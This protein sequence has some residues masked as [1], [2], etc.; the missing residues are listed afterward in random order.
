MSKSDGQRR[1]PPEGLHEVSG[2]FGMDERAFCRA[3]WLARTDRGAR[4]SSLLLLQDP[5]EPNDPFWIID[6]C[7]SCG[8]RVA[9]RAMVPVS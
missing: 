9:Y 8:V 6:D 1:L 4:P 7:S 5:N 2:Y 3:C